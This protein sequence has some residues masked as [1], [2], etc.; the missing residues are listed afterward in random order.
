MLNATQLPLFGEPGRCNGPGCLAPLFGLAGNGRPLRYCSRR[1]IK[2]AYM[3]RHG[4]RVNAERRERERV[5]YASD[6]EWRAKRIER[7]KAR[8]AADPE[9]F[10]A[11]RSRRQVEQG[12]EIRRRERERY[13]Q[14]PTRKR[15]GAKK[16]AR[17]NR[18]KATLIQQRR[19]VRKAGNDSR[20]VLDRD[21]RRMKHRQRGACFYCGQ[22]GRLTIE[23]LIPV[24][25]GGRDSIGNYVLACHSCNASKGN[26]TV[27]EYR[28]GRKRQH[29]G[30]GR[31][32]DLSVRQS[33]PPAAGAQSAA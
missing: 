19:R 11:A 10:R 14:D 24:S 9:R 27:M 3:Q 29:G 5:K 30:R 20:R 26:R 6:P 32:D 21:L 1:C 23:H 4:D 22:L 7:E 18:A 16:W 12:E 33:D 15:E 17:A 8:Y 31:N 13:A 25:R 2:A 28:L